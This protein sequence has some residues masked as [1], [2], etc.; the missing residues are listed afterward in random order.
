LYIEGIVVEKTK[1]NLEE[2]F[3]IGVADIDQDVGEF[4][5]IYKINADK[6]AILHKN[7]PKPTTKISNKSITAGSQ[8]KSAKN[9]IPIRTP[10]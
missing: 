2:L 1:A 3:N 4:G 6:D 8:L 9:K 7:F 5:V 10:S